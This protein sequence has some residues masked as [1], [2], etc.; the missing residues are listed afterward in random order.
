M[1]ELTKD[2]IEQLKHIIEQKDDAQAQAL[3]HDLYPADIA[4]LYQ[5]DLDNRMSNT[6]SILEPTLVI[7]LSLVVG[8]ILLSV[9]L[10]LVGIMSSI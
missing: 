5:E 1:I 3:I 2:Y 9:M 8:F 4:E 7:A 10:P 6:L